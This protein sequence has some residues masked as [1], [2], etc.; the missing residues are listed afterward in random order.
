M[1]TTAQR[2]LIVAEAATGRGGG[3]LFPSESFDGVS[4]SQDEVLRQSRIYSRLYEELVRALAPAMA[5]RLGVAESAAAVLSRRAIVPIAHVLGDR[6]LRLDRAAAGR[7]CAVPEGPAL[8]PPRDVEAFLASASSSAAF[9][10]ALLRRLGPAVSAVP[11]AAPLPGD[12]RPPSAPSVNRNFDQARGLLALAR[13]A[14]ARLLGAPLSRRFGRFPALSMAYAVGPMKAAGFYALQLRELPRDWPL[15]AAARDGALREEAL[16]GPLREGAARW[17]AS[18]EELGMSARAAAFF[19]E[20][21]PRFVADMFPLAFLEGAPTNIAVAARLLS[22][23]RAGSLLYAEAGD[24]RDALVLAAARAAGLRL[25][26][27]QHGGHY[28]YLADNVDAE[29]IEYALCDEFVSWGWTRLPDTPACARVRVT[30]LPTPWLS[31][32][33]RLRRGRSGRPPAEKPFDL[34]LMSNK[35]KRFG[36]APTG[37]TLSRRDLIRPFS[38]LLRELVS[39]AAARGVS[40]LHKPYG[41]ATR[42]ILARTFA[43][44]ER[45]GGS[46]YADAG[47]ADKGLSDALL[48]RARLVAWDQPGTGFLECIAS[49]IPTLVLWPRLYNQEEPFAREDFA[50]LERAGIVHRTVD[51]L[52]AE[53]LAF[54]A[55]PE[56]WLGDAARAEALRAFSRRYGWADDGWSGRLTDFLRD[57]P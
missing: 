10:E 2:V 8:E 19:A 9:N 3:A 24:T 29:E 20:E 7:E 38:E 54:R 56:R 52:L 42:E 23:R 45:L 48:D 4:F 44:L 35:I 51:G 49:G 25:V 26:C 13:R 33:A 16:A 39:K 30:P 50:A 34:L 17:R 14:A 18:A 37:A 11:V 43:D 5:R 1:P 31:E 40:I 22:P 55:D 28:G 21:L 36:Q 6:L 27:F 15:A 12:A 46:F 32:R 57:L 47:T 53:A 41:G